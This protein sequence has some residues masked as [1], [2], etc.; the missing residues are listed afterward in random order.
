MITLSGLNWNNAAQVLESVYNTNLAGL[1]WDNGKQRVQ[2]VHNSLYEN[3]ISLELLAWYTGLPII[4][5]AF[6]NAI[7]IT[8]EPDMSETNLSGLGLLATG[9]TGIDA[10]LIYLNSLVLSNTDIYIDGNEDPT[11]VSLTA[12][13]ELEFRGCVIYGNEV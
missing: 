13:Q 2:V 12:R 1:T 8:N 3:K 7:P 11:I 9:D 5:A 4:E 6:N 10:R